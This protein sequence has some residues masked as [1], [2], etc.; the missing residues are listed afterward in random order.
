L[1]WGSSVKVKLK[2]TVFGLVL[3]QEPPPP[4]HSEAESVTTLVAAE[5]LTV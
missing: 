3:L 1:Y 4:V 5:V 2:V